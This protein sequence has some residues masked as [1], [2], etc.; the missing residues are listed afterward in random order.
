M[1]THFSNGKLSCFVQTENWCNLFSFVRE[2]CWTLKLDLNGNLIHPFSSHILSN[3][4]FRDF[5]NKTK[6]WGKLFVK[7]HLPYRDLWARLG[8]DYHFW[9]ASV[10]YE[11]KNSSRDV[12]IIQS[13][14][15][16]IIRRMKSFDRIRGL[17]VLNLSVIISN[18][19]NTFGILLKSLF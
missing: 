11:V 10:T 15:K 9:K 17:N 4:F 14:L 16:R 6:Q 7:L 19:N 2:V 5:A 3:S 12:S 1:Q 13:W 18:P 8:E